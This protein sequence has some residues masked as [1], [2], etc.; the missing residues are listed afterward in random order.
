MEEY[1][2]MAGEGVGGG[3]GVKSGADKLSLGR[4]VG[5]WR[6]WDA[7]TLALTSFACRQSHGRGREGGEAGG[8][9]QYVYAALSSDKP[10]TYSSL[11]LRA[12][13]RQ[14]GAGA[15]YGGERGGGA[16]Q[17]VGGGVREEQSDGFRT[18]GRG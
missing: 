16:G 10:H 6:A 18:T 11:S 5:S 9:L 12:G 2:R 8:R 1:K 14:L 4:W 7:R 3:G 17:L 13:W 15:G